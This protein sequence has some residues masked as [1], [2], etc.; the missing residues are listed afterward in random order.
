MAF[1][2]SPHPSATGREVMSMK[3]F[4]AML[5]VAAALLVGIAPAFAEQTV[6][7]PALPDPKVAELPFG[8]FSESWFSQG[9]FLGD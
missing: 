6:V 7:S 4:A 3:K 9:V 5:L 1:E 2:G 8:I